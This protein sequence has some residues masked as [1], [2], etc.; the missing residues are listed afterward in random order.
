MTI[1][2]LLSLV[3]VEGAQ[4]IQCIALPNILFCVLILLI[5]MNMYHFF[6]EISL[7]YHYHF[8]EEKITLHLCHF[9]SKAFFSKKKSLINQVWIKIVYPGAPVG[10]AR[11]E[12]VPTK[13]WPIC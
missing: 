12:P 2:K 3:E 4:L 8:H 13:F 1:N 7:A 5:F 9:F 10:M 11:W 6:I